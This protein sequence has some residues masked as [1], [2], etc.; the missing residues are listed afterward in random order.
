MIRGSHTETRITLIPTT[1]FLLLQ[2]GYDHYFSAASETKKA[3]TQIQCEVLATTMDIP[4]KMDT[5]KGSRP[6]HASFWKKVSV[7]K[8][9]DKDYKVKSWLALKL[10]INKFSCKTPCFNIA[11]LVFWAKIHLWQSRFP[12]DDN[13]MTRPWHHKKAALSFSSLGCSCLFINERRLFLRRKSQRVPESS[14][15]TP[16]SVVRY[17]QNSFMLA[18][19]Y[20]QYSTA[21]L[22]A[23]RCDKIEKY[24]H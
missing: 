4:Q 10:E 9:F 22:H 21:S 8:G 16:V 12:L 15:T 13:A 24:N 11:W 18:T 14:W 7:D 1:A 23:S 20:F 2:Q 5:R 17:R 3:K 6:P 19:I